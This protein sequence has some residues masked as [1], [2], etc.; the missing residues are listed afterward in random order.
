MD[1]GNTFR[2]AR[3][4]GTAVLG[5]GNSPSIEAAD[6]L[7]SGELVEWYR[8]RIKGRSSLPL[9]PVLTFA[10]GE[11]VNRMQVFQG[12]NNQPR[13]SIARLDTVN[14]QQQRNLPPGTYFIK[15]SGTP[16]PPNSGQF[17]TFAARISLFG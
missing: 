3:F 13:K 17:A 8:F 15:I 12:I 9:K 6:T 11:F 10:G 14:S 1:G 5:R 7:A 4:L 16:A 2:Q